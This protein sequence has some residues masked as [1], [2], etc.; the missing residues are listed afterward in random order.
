MVIQHNLGA[1]FSQRQLGITTGIKAK[2]SEKLSSGYRINRAADDAAGLAISEKMR[3]QIRGLSQDMDNIQDGVSFCQVADSYLNEIHDMIQ[4]INELAVKGANDTLTD[5]D[6]EYIDMEVQDTKTEMNRIF[7]SASF[8]EMKIFKLPYTPYVESDPEPYDIQIFYST[9]NTIGGL[10]F[11][12]IRYNIQELINE[13][14]KLDSSGIA[15][16]DQTVEFNLYDG[17]RVSLTLGEGESLASVRRNYYWTADDTGIYVND[18]QAVTWTDLGISGDGNDAGTYSFS[19]HGMNIEFD[20]EEGDALTDILDGINGTGI[21]SASHWD[22]SVSGV[23]NRSVAKYLSCNSVTVTNSNCDV[24]ADDFYITA[25]TTGLSITDGTLGTSTS[26]TAW[27]NFSNVGGTIER[28]PAEETNGGY[29]I[30]DWGLDVDSNDS[31]EITFETEATYRYTS[32]D[33]TLPITY[34]FKLADVS[35]RDEV[36]A[37]MNET[38]LVGSITCP[39]VLTTG[40]TSDSSSFSI[41]DSRITGNDNNA[42][43][44]QRDY[45]RDFDTNADLT[46]SITWTSTEVEDSETDHSTP[47]YT[48]TT[49]QGST[50]T[51]TGPNAYY[52]YDSD[53]GNYYMYDETV[54]TTVSSSQTTNVYQWDKQYNIVYDGTLGTSDMQDETE[55]VAIG[56]TQTDVI[57]SVTT[58]VA[59]SYTN[60]TLLTEDEVT[61]LQESGATFNESATDSSESSTESNTS[62][63]TS[64]SDGTLVHTQNYIDEDEDDSDN[65]ASRSLVYNILIGY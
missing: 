52:V 53:S 35:S 36:I 20:V 41:Y 60:Q 15:T 13:G 11:N 8:N 58:T 55:T 57:D 23:T 39:A 19:F 21:V 31:G 45:G 61:A 54:T 1:M 18:V 16:E 49:D 2:S 7:K 32:P 51:T 28:T 27:A 43:I 10:E 65:Y 29:P 63:T 48:Y 64:V 40:S 6:R 62:S 34:T 59:Y 12:N 5:E 56:I 50:S 14:M 22:L 46:G 30:V 37:A 44:L 33:S 25:D 42:F 38:E 3:R 26:T 24:I 4:R 9:Q 47:A 17:E